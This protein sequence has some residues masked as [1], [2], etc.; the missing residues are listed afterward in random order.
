MLMIHL[1]AGDGDAQYRDE[2]VSIPLTIGDPV[3]PGCGI[4]KFNL[5]WAYP[6]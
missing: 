1:L 2:Y 3:R 5:D 6:K 4:N